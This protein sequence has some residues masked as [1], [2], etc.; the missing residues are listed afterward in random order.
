MDWLIHYPT[1]T[2]TMEL[3]TLPMLV[4]LTIAFILV[5]AALAFSRRLAVIDAVEQQVSQ[6]SSQTSRR[7]S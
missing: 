2:L 1:S 5:P 7:I 4:L 6:I 3:V